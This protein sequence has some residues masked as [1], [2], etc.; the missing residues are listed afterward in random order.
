MSASR[1]KVSEHVFGRLVAGATSRRNLLVRFPFPGQ[2]LRGEKPCL[3]GGDGHVAAQA[4][5]P[6]FVHGEL[7][8]VAFADVQRAPDLLGQGE[9]CFPDGPSHGPAREVPVRSCQQA[10]PWEAPSDFP[11]LPLYHSAH[12]PGGRAGHVPRSAGAPA[13]PAPTFS[14]SAFPARSDRPWTTGSRGG[15]RRQEAG[16]VRLARA[17][18]QRL[19]EGG[20]PGA[21]Q[22]PAPERCDPAGPDNRSMDQCRSVSWSRSRVCS[23]SSG[24]CPSALR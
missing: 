21:Q 20:E 19:A 3:I 6:I 15:L 9:L 8:L 24:N 23:L 7:H 2:P 17:Q 5:R 12:C 14:L 22:P 4:D 11:T 10:H 1:V 18:V 13:P 16:T